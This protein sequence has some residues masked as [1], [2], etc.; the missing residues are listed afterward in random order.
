MATEFLDDHPTGSRSRVFPMLISGLLGF[1][2]GNA[3]LIAAMPTTDF[4]LDAHPLAAPSAEP[5][6]V[7]RGRQAD[8][9][10]LEG[11]ADRWVSENCG[12]SEIGSANWWW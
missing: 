2:L 4:V 9:A 5:W 10:R 11:L 12:H 7:E 1:L 6:S 3:S 8:A